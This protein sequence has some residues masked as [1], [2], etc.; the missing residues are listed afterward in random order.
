MVSTPPVCAGPSASA[1][2]MSQN[3]TPLSPEQEYWRARYERLKQAFCADILKKP[4]CSR[5]ELNK[6]LLLWTRSQFGKPA[7]KVLQWLFESWH[8]NELAIRMVRAAC[9]DHLNMLKAL[10]ASHKCTRWQAERMAEA[11]MKDFE[12]IPGSVVSSDLKQDALESVDVA[13]RL[14]AAVPEPFEG[15]GALEAYCNAIRLNS[16]IAGV[17]AA[18]TLMLDCMLQHPGILSSG[19]PLNTLGQQIN[20][21]CAGQGKE[22]QK[23]ID[24]YKSKHE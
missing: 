14:A 8:R 20:K 18:N 22:V 23:Y 10:V 5:S 19:R 9:A 4:Q 12:E 24:A 16:F 11:L 15:A 3:P 2:E 21:W 17:Q 1:T 13:A 7:G 6:S